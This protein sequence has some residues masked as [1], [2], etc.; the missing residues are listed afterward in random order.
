MSAA[1]P[2]SK[3]RATD[4]WRK[5]ALDAATAAS[6]SKELRSAWASATT[7]AQARGIRACARGGRGAAQLSPR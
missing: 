4:R 3:P 7:E 6:R 5:Q 2:V 1:A